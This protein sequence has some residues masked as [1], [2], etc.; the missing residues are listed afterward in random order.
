M[1]IHLIQHPQN[2]L[3]LSFQCPVCQTWNCF[4]FA[5]HLLAFNISKAKSKHICFKC[6]S[7]HD[8]NIYTAGNII[9]KNHNIVLDIK[10]TNYDVD[11]VDKLKELIQF[12]RILGSVDEKPNVKKFSYN[13]FDNTFED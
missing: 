4:N 11:S 9:L 5:Y 2:P 7:Y 1:S 6:N 10:S 12:Y 3:F 13:P 8:F